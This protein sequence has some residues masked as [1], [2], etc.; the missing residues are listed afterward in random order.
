[1]FSLWNQVRSWAR[2]QWREDW[3]SPRRLKARTV[4][5]LVRSLPN[6]EEKKKKSHIDYCLWIIRGNPPH[7]HDPPHSPT[8]PHPDSSLPAEGSIHTV[9]LPRSSI[10]VTSVVQPSHCWHAPLL[11]ANTVLLSSST[12]HFR[13]CRFQWLFWYS[14]QRVMVHVWRRVRCAPA[15]EFRMAR[16]PAWWLRCW[17]NVVN[18]LLSNSV[19]IV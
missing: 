3:C 19:W 11:W 2:L 9:L 14:R 1:M 7:H 5:L 13:G 10:S 4:S 16:K 8:Q 18:L 12:A 17:S 6:H 15:G